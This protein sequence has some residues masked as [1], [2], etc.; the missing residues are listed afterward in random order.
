MERG[1]LSAALGS[2]HKRILC[3]HSDRAGVSVDRDLLAGDDSRRDVSGSHDRGN[4]VTRERR[5]SRTLVEGKTPDTES[6]L[7]GKR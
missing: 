7:I 2:L 1:R 4:A 3:V 5:S 6:E